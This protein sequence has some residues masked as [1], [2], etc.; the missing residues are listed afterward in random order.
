MLTSCTFYFNLVC[1]FSLNPLCKNLFGLQN[2]SLGLHKT[3]NWK[4][5]WWNTHVSVIQVEKKT[6]VL[7]RGWSCVP[8]VAWPKTFPLS[9]AVPSSLLLSPV[10]TFGVLSQALLMVPVQRLCST[11][12]Q[13]PKLRCSCHPQ[14]PRSLPALLQRW[15]FCSSADIPWVCRPFQLE[16]PR[17]LSYNYFGVRSFWA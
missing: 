15:L 11:S 14:W 3:L 7:E 16:R 6:Q 10:V 5:W 8:V 12:W 9:K 1:F 4:L 13:G 17:S 2:W